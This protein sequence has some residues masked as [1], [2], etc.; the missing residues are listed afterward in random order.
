MKNAT[1][2]KTIFKFCSIQVSSEKYLVPFKFAGKFV[3]FK[4]TSWFSIILG[5]CMAEMNFREH[6]LKVANGYWKAFILIMMLLNQKFVISGKNWIQE[7]Q[8]VIFLFSITRNLFSVI[9]VSNKRN[10]YFM[11]L[12]FFLSEWRIKICYSTNLETW[13]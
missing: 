11:Q 6:Q 7:K 2:L 1:N 8:L 9:H 12:K 3:F 13:F 4:V 5:Y 10:I